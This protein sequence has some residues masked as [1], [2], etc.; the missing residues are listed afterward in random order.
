MLISDQT[1]LEKTL[2]VE[3]LVVKIQLSRYSKGLYRN[4]AKKC[5]GFKKNFGTILQCEPESMSA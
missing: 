1:V 2:D 4:I 3:R 5:A